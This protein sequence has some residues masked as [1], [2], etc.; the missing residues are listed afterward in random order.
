MD[1]FEYAR[2]VASLFA[3][4]AS[5]LRVKQLMDS[6]TASLNEVGEVIQLDPVLTAKLLKLA[7]SSIYNLSSPVDTI[8]RALLVLGKEQ[9][10]SLLLSIGIS[11]ACSKVDT[12]AIDIQRFWEQSINAALI[13]RYLAGRCQLKQ[14][15]RLYVAGLLHN[16]GEL[17]VL[18]VNARQAHQCQ[19]YNQT[20]TPW[21]R[22]QNV[23][24]FTYA[25][26]GAE[27]LHL[28]QIPDTIAA[29]LALQHDTQFN[30]KQPE[31]L[32]LYLAVRL[33]LVNQHPEFYNTRTLIDPFAIELLDLT[34]QDMLKALDFC[35]TEGVFLL[36]VLNPNI[37]TIY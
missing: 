15:D 30:Q 24:G 26:C 23:L 35:N 20:E 1:A 12:A 4:P 5:Y 22:Q 37:S 32:I 18:H 33:A 17:V 6:D 34:M 10:Y 13:A 25:S 9:I 19:W 29:P 27:L 36:S 21:Q 2:D 31:Q 14:P 3:L 8:S 16:I 7:N 11:T 28:W